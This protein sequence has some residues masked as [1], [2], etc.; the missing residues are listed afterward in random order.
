MIIA[1]E[2]QK[3]KEEKIYDDFVKLRKEKAKEQRKIKKLKA[4]EKK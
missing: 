3:E 2:Q 4:L 1:K